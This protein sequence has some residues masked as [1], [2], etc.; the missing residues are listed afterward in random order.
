MMCF[1]HILFIG[2]RFDEERVPK[3]ASF[4]KKE[5]RGKKPKITMQLSMVSR[6]SRHS[7]RPDL[8]SFCGDI[9]CF[10]NAIPVL[11]VNCGHINR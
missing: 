11:I 1:G 6:E 8:S 3:P 9:T 5:I 2:V 4:P 10:Y 7:W